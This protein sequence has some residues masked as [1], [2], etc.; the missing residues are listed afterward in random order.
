MVDKL[1]EHEV[2]PCGKRAMHPVRFAALVRFCKY[3][4]D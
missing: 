3:V 2:I 4:N 1:V